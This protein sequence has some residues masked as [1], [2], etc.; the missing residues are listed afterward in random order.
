MT[1]FQINKSV[2]SIHNQRARITRAIKIR[3]SFV[4]CSSLSFFFS[5]FPAS[6]FWTHNRERYWSFYFF[7]F[8]FFFCTQTS[9]SPAQILSGAQFHF[10]SQFSRWLFQQANYPQIGNKNDV[11]TK[12]NIFWLWNFRNDS[13]L[14]K[15]VI[16]FFFK[17]GTLR[18]VSK[19]KIALCQ[20]CFLRR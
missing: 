11:R 5:I 2:W 1:E 9:N 3:V 8:F 18:N 16:F 6:N 4:F 17:R 15:H 10:D 20:S 19:K 13:L 14:Y 12:E 7:S